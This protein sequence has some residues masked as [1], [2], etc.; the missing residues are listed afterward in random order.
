MA[1]VHIQKQLPKNSLLIVN[2][3]DI[4]FIDVTD[5]IW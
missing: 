1:V 5:K 2:D 3:Y 4:Y